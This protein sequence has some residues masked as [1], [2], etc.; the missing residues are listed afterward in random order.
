ML[1]EC[2]VR[3]ESPNPKLIE[4][5]GIYRIDI[6][7]A[8]IHSPYLDLMIDSKFSDIFPGN[9]DEV[10]ADFSFKVVGVPY[11][12]GASALA[13]KEAF[14]RQM[15][16][17]TERLIAWSKSPIFLEEVAAI[18]QLPMVPVR[19]DLVQQLIRREID[20]PTGIN[21][22]EACPYLIQWESFPLEVV[23]Y[24]LDHNPCKAALLAGW[25]AQA[26]NS[27]LPELP[28]VWTKLLE[29][30]FPDTWELDDDNALLLM[31]RLYL[32]VKD[33]SNPKD[34]WFAEQFHTRYPATVEVLKE[35]HVMLTQLYDVSLQPNDAARNVSLLRHV[36]D[37]KKGITRMP[38]ILSELDEV[39]PL[40]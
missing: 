3:C 28:D 14:E 21:F 23:S 30:C 19:L 33:A 9:F 35:A 20:H 2:I 15:S 1:V 27:G 10:C 39:G 12:R 8:A 6:H 4:L 22:F 11:P 40:A 5:D 16:E 34:Q 26:R 25:S 36:L 37:I 18:S 32:M 17:S 38:L 29:C 7:E 24:H 31:W 13:A